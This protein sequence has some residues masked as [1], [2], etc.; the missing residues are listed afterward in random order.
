MT[1]FETFVDP[2]RAF[3]LIPFWFLND[4]LSEDELRRQ[5]DEF[6]AHRVY[7]FVP[8]PRIGLPETIGFMSGVWLHYVRVC[9][10]HA[11]RRGMIVV[12]YDEGM[13][14]SGSCAG[15]V[16]AADPRH[17]TRCL[18]RRPRKEGRADP[19]LADNEEVVAESDAWVYVHTRSQGRIRGVHYGMDDGEP[20]APA[21]ADLLNPAATASFLHLVHDRYYDALKDHFGPTVRGF[22]TDEPSVLGRGPIKGVLPWTWGFGDYVEG[23]LGYDMRVHLDALFDRDHADHARRSA[24]F[25]RVV[26]ARLQKAYYSPYKAW[27]DA[28]ETSLMGHPAGPGDMGALRY[29][30]VPG[31]D[32]VWRYIEP[33]K[34]SALEGA[35][36]TM[37]KCS[38]SAQRHFGRER[39]ANE[40]FG[41]YG[42][43]FTYEE[44]RW[45]TNWL[46][47]RGVNMLFP[48]A[49]YYSLR[50]ERRNERPPDVGP[51]SVWW[52]DYKTY[53]DFCR[54]LCW[55][56]SQGRHVCSIA[57]VGTSSEL[58]WR[59]A[60]V[61]FESQ[62]D[63]NYIDPATLLGSAYMSGAGI[64]IEGME[65]KAVIIDGPGYAPAEATAA[66]EPLISAGRVI[67][68]MDPIPG[69]PLLAQ[70]A[71]RLGVLLDRLA[72][73]DVRIE[74]PAKDLRYIHMRHSEGDLYLLTNEGP[75]PIEGR[76]HVAVKKGCEWWDPEIAS[77]RIAGDPLRI[78]IEPYQAQVLYCGRNGV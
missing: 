8:H 64:R 62:R 45:I 46:F 16:A 77:R 14:P 75:A 74:P 49:F 23:F 4:A 3:T 19:P 29:L 12:L 2:P 28:H 47:V 43:E 9:V 39:N 22:F 59:V 35:Q 40:C 15:Q 71:E 36:S 66:L 27:C 30:H 54:R 37:A 63:F 73:P 31:Q 34:D 42:W 7:G 69:V 18:E 21:S 61:L 78:A 11:A 72:P 57:I 67:A 55:L 24:D 51:N 1:L 50:G 58:P 70:N 10:E 33:F 68:Y 44:M 5:I 60:R 52:D 53:A 65:Y 20:G 56:L 25:R 41:A 48:H 13:Y 6:A 76:L 26:D 32:V 38:S 17:A